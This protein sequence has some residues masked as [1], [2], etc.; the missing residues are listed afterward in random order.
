MRSSF[1]VDIEIRLLRPEDENVLRALRTS[2]AGAGGTSQ[3]DVM[4]TFSSADD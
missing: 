1:I 4:W 3:T 2:D